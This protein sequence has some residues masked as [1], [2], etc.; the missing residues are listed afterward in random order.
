MA[1]KWATHTRFW[2]APNGNIYAA[3]LSTRGSMTTR[4]RAFVGGSLRVP[5]NSR[6]DFRVTALAGPLTNWK[7]GQTAAG[8]LRRA[9]K[10]RRSALATRVNKRY[11]FGPLTQY[12]AGSPPRRPAPR[13]KSPLG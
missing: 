8:F 3:R 13:R 12:P 11:G 4:A 7:P 10:R 5:R 9:G 2:E 6:E 1:K